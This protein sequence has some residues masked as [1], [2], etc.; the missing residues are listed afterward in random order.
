MKKK[1]VVKIT[2]FKTRLIELRREL[3]SIGYHRV[4]ITNKFFSLSYHSPTY[5]SGATCVVRLLFI[6]AF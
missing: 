6:F 2:A 1:K 4:K 3:L 5:N